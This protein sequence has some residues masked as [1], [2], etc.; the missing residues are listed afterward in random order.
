MAKRYQQIA[1]EDEGGSVVACEIT[2]LL[3]KVLTIS[4]RPLTT[5]E[6]SLHQKGPKVQRNGQLLSLSFTA[7][8]DLK[9][10]SMNYLI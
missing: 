5:S 3:G 2:P 7:T 9:F 1:T 6:V 10:N 4:S 8:Y